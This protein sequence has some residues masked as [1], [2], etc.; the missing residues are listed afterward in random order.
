MVKK[1]FC[2]KCG[3][4]VERLYNGLCKDCFLQTLDVKELPSKIKVGQCRYCGKYFVGK[5]KEGFVRL[6]DA[7]EKYFKEIRKQPNVKGVSYKIKNNMIELNIIMSA[8]GLRKV[9]KKSI[10]FSIKKMTCPVCTLKKTGYYTAIMQIIA[11]RY[12]LEKVVGYTTRRLKSLERKDE[13]AYV[14]SIE[15]APHGKVLKV[16][17]KQAAMKVAREL[18]EKFGAKLK[19]STT[20]VTYKKGKNLYRLTISIRVRSDG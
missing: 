5:S 3:R 2:P 18:K 14:A 4:E 15:D 10:P 19:Y 11:P 16:G 17:S 8:L 13:L 7:L 20:L 9:V 6:G 12:L 1:K